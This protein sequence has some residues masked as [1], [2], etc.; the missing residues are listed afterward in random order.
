MM[1]TNI[2][3]SRN[4]SQKLWYKPTAGV[5]STTYYASPDST[6]S[7]LHPP[8]SIITAIYA[9]ILASSC[10]FPN[11]FSCDFPACIYTPKCTIPLLYTLYA[12]NMCVKCSLPAY[13]LI[14]TRS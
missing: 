11:V 3:N 4:S 6:L 13:Q 10:S 1:L 2:C 7:S 5:S 12:R 14:C 8:S 9:C